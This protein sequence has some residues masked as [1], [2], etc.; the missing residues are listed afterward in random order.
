MKSI[1]ASIALLLAACAGGEPV[2]ETACAAGGPDLQEVEPLQPG[3]FAV[4]RLIVAG[5]T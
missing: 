5:S 3:A 1:L 4:L 2:A